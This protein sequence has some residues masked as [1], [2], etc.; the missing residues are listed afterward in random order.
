MHFTN[1]GWSLTDKYLSSCFAGTPVK[2]CFV[3]SRACLAQVSLPGTTALM[4]TSRSWTPNNTRFVLNTCDSAV[5]MNIIEL[6]K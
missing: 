1:V 3:Q 6:I 2:M 5:C 4:A